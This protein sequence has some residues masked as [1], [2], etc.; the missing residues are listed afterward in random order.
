[1]VGPLK[2]IELYMAELYLSMTPQQQQHF[3]KNN[4]NNL[5]LPIKMVMAMAKAKDPFPG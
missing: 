3:N 5:F 4:L 1:M 2:S